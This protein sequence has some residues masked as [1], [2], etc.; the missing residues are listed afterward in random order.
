[1]SLTEE[2]KRKLGIETMTSFFE[3]FGNDVYGKIL[4]EVLFEELFQVQTK[5]K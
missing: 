5:E 4:M 1:M 3:Q 2:E